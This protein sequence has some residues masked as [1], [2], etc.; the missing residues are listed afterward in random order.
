MKLPNLSLAW[1]LLLKEPGYSAVVILGLAFGLAACFLLLGLLRFS[2][3]YNSQIP[4]PQRTYVVLERLNLVGKPEWMEWAPANLR[5]IAKNSGL[6]LQATAMIPQ[7]VNLRHGTQT[8]HLDVSLVEGAFPRIFGITAIEG[9]LSAALT[10]PDAGTDRTNRKAVVRQHACG[11]PNAA[12]QTAKLH[13]AG[14]D[15]RCTGQYHGAVS[16]AGRV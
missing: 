15:T 11:G 3:S 16:G 4:A 1:R 2:L 9:D 5:D 14:G 10:R 7:S 12:N 8:V 6:Q 13:C